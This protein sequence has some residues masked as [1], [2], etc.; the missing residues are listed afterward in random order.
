M[1]AGETNGSGVVEEAVLFGA[2]GTLAGVVTTPAGRGADDGAPAV[3]LLNAGATHHVGPNRL[4]V[5]IARELALSGHVVLRYDQSGIGDSEPRRDGVAYADGVLSETREAMDFLGERY[6]V[7]RFVLGGICSGGATAFVAARRDPRVVGALMI[8]A[9]GHFHADCPDAIA[10]AYRRALRRHT[11]RLALFSSFRRQN[12]R[13]LFTGRLGLRRTVTMALGGER[14]PPAPVATPVGPGP[15]PRAEVEEL[16]R[17]GVRLFHLYGEGDQGLDYFR[18]VLGRDAR[19][20]AR[21]EAFRVRVL[22]GVNH[23]FTQRWG[24]D[25]LVEAV[26]DWIGGVRAERP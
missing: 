17:R 19:A 25:V 26:H 14:R 15:N 20:L 9:Q 21:D 11:W 8:N 7:G 24:Q 12:W 22:A 13:K 1:R 5:R 10:D 4:Y 23:V 3:V 2:R 16:L 18:V 6:G